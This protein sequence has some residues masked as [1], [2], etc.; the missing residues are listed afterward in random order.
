M[1]PVYDFHFLF[2]KKHSEL[3]CVDTTSDKNSKTFNVRSWSVGSVEG[4]LSNCPQ[5]R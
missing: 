5:Q 4:S 3:A 2:Q 1:T